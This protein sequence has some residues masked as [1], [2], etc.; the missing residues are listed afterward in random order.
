VVFIPSA[1]SRGLSMH[2]WMIEQTSHAIAN[3]YVLGTINRVGQESDLGSNDY[4]GPSYFCDPRGQLV[5]DLASEKD[6]ELLI[7][8]L[9]IELVRE[10]H[11]T[12]QFY[13]DRR[14]E[15]YDEIVALWNSGRSL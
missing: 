1:T 10:V 13:H 14:P 8:E 3:S 5:G 11:N 2:L 12:W 4:Y 9:N 6:E 15:L 7:H